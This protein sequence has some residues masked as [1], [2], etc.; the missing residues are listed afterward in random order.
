MPQ[1]CASGHASTRELP[2][3]D[4][5]PRFAA[6]EVQSHAARTVEAGRLYRV[7]SLLIQVGL[8]Q[9]AVGRRGKLR[10]YVRGKN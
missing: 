1:E 9:N 6:V 10:V 3:G 7:D 5:E 2:V 4:V 8:P